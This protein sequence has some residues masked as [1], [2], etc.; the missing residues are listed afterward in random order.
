MFFY[1]MSKICAIFVSNSSAIALCECSCRV[2]CAFSLRIY[3][4]YS[5]TICCDLK[6]SRFEATIWGRLKN[7]QVKLLE[8]I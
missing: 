6:R 7:W 4:V 2:F 3:E 8:N 5:A 1:Y